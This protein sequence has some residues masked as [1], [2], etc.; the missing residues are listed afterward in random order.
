MPSIAILENQVLAPLTT[1]GIGGAARYF[2]TAKKV[3]DVI[4]GLEWAN[5]NAIPVCILGGGS[6]VLFAD[7]GWPGLVIHLCLRGIVV[8]RRGDSIRLSVQ[9]GE[10]WDGLVETAVTNHWAGIEC[11]SG[12]P[13]FVGATPIQNVGAYGQAVSECIDW[14]DCLALDSLRIVRFQA[15]TCQFGY[16]TSIFKT[17]VRDQNLILAVGF[18]LH[19]GGKPSVRYPDLVR[20]LEDGCDLLDVRRTVLEIRHQ[21]A[22]IIA[23]SEPNS[24]GCGSFFTNPIL[25]K[26]AY[27]AFQQKYIGSHPHFLDGEGRV[28]ISAAW[29][30]EQAGFPKGYCHKNVGLSQ[31]HSLAIINRGN[32]TAKQVLELAALICQTVTQRFGIIL[33]PEPVLWS[34]EGKRLALPNRPLAR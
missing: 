16:R 20:R 27:A 5:K 34:E 30:I 17:S 11:L 33:Q 10:S 22:M 4:A 6:N 9:A 18:R 26:A 31:K 23:E 32:G 21:K 12:I 13:G 2:L 3:D 15:G 29:L 19:A 24:R 8:D 28:K 25:E 14:V 1:I 7:E